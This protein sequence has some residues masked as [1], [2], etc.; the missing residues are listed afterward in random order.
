MVTHWYFS[1]FLFDYGD[2]TWTKIDAG[3]FPAADPIAFETIWAHFSNAANGYDR[4]SFAW[5]WDTGAKKWNLVRR[6]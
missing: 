1:K 5:E 4:I 6:A 3:M 2:R